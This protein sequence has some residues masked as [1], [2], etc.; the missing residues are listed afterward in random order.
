MLYLYCTQT[1]FTLSL[2][3]KKT[4][5]LISGSST[6]IWAIREPRCQ[7]KRLTTVWINTFKRI[8][9]WLAGKRNKASLLFCPLALSKRLRICGDRSK[10]QHMTHRAEEERH[11]T[12]PRRD[13]IN[14]CIQVGFPFSGTQSFSALLTSVTWTNGPGAPD[15]HTDCPAFFLFLCRANTQKRYFSR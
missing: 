10:S 7:A 8:C 5:V 1:V 4:H 15:T 2:L 11:F 6:T 14:T 12:K 3:N 9:Q 13:L